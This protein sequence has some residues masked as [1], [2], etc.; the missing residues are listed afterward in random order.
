MTELLNFM[1][2]PWPWYISGPLIGLTVPLLFWLGNKS[3]G[4]S[5]NLR[6]ACAILLPENQKPSFFQYDWSKEKWNIMFAIGLLV[7]GFIAGFLF[8]NPQPVALSEGG[9]EAIHALGVQHQAGL[10]PSELRDLSNPFVWAILALSGLLVGF[11]TR[12][13]GGCTSGHAITGLSTLQLPSLIATIAFFSG[14][15]LSANLFLPFLMR[16]ITGNPS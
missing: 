8:A 16:L 12:Y 10:V 3:F 6:H 14:G 4:I 5:G 15:I 13:G 2:Q 1:Q 11:G 9:K 7:G